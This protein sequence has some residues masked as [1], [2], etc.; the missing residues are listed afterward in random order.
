MLADRVP[1]E[2]LENARI[3]MANATQTQHT[4]TRSHRHIRNIRQLFGVRGVFYWFYAM[5]GIHSF[6]WEL[7][8]AK[9]NFLVES[10]ISLWCARWM[11]FY[12]LWSISIGRLFIFNWIG[13]ISCESKLSV[14]VEKCDKKTGNSVRKIKSE[15][16]GA[17]VGT[18]NTAYFRRFAFA[19]IAFCAKS[20]KY[21]HFS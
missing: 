21:S 20:K 19:F 7:N 8:G 1:N 17:I 12:H 11:E 2:S 9:R 3:C 14:K 15:Q 18:K 4:V 10:K 6:R 16:K 5:H 13:R